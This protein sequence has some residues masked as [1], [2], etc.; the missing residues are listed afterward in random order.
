MFEARDFGKVYLIVAWVML[1]SIIAMAGEAP[2]PETA[3]IHLVKGDTA[4][5][6]VVAIGRDDLLSRWILAEMDSSGNDA[7]GRAAT[8]FARRDFASC[9]DEIESLPA[10]STAADRTHLWLREGA[11]LVE[12]NRV[13]EADSVL[14]LAI[15][16]ARRQSMPVSQCFGLLTRG[17]GRVRTR[18]VEPPR[19]DLL[20]AVV[21][22]DSL[23]LPGWGGSAAIALSVVS[24]LQMDLA[25]ALQWR[26]QALDLYL[27][28]S[29]IRGQ[30]VATHYIGTIQLMQGDLTR[31]MQ[32]F[33]DALVL[34]RNAGER[35]TEGG[36]LGEMASVNYLLGNF[37]EA[38][39]QYHE[40]IRL[41]NNPWQRGMMLINIGSIHEYRGQYAEA[42][43]VQREAL[44]LMRQV[45]DHRTE[46]AA[47]SSLG[48][49]LCEL[50]Q[51]E[52]GLEYLDEAVSV[53][54]EY[55]IPMYEAFALKSK[56]HG[57]LDSGDNA[58]AILALREAT[59]VARQIDYFEILEYSLLGQAMVARREERLTEALQYLEE[60]LTEVAAVRRRSAGSSNVTSGV[61]GQAGAIY[62]EA[63]DLLWTMHQTETG[64]GHDRRA[65]DIA[66]QAKARSFLDLLSE[67]EF[68]LKYSAVPGYR[69]AESEILTRMI[70]AE[71]TLLEAS[72]A[73]KSQRKAELAAVENELQI[74]EARLRAEDQRYA[75]VLYKK[76]L[77][78]K[79][80]QEQVL[81]PDELFLEYAL[82]DSASFV[83]AISQRGAR[84]FE[85]APRSLIEAR[86]RE[87][88]PLLKD[89]NLTGGEIAWLQPVA[90]ELARL[91]LDP[92]AAEISA[93]DRLLISPDGILHYLPFEV[94]LLSDE[95]S[96]EACD[97]PWLVKE[98]VVTVTP[99]A[100]VLASVLARPKVIEAAPWLLV[101]DPH[102]VGNQESGL[103]AKAAGAGD[104]EPLLNVAIELDVLQNLAPN[105]GTQ[106]LRAGAATVTALRE[107]GLSTSW[108]QVHFATHGL[109]N[110]DRPR[111]S[112]LVLSPDPATGDDGFL[113][114]SDVFGLQ[115]NCQQVVLSAC[116]TAL[117]ENVTGEGLVGL[118]QGFLFSGARSVIASLW[119]VS[120]SATTAFMAIYYDQL[121]RNGGDRALA[122]AVT[123]RIL[124][125]DGGNENLSHPAYWSA[126]VLSGSGH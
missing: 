80:L 68:D 2:V 71:T 58:G 82:G 7:L 51:F 47:L 125:C 48:E 73:H 63:V 111:Y 6:H 23:D 106:Q 120:G 98:K 83:W 90:R 67:A 99:S 69:Q 77:F 96:T 43:V 97:L 22:C 118:T 27:E 75:D 20:A 33:Q 74:L 70:T 41:A 64:A 21:L 37:N 35:T 66:Q 113:S 81:A 100:S 108:S 54:R 52:E 104:L 72:A 57:L 16:E 15:D 85:L 116:S 5:A 32:N 122:L 126:F 92:V 9:L 101:G 28:A 42:V 46:A 38:L 79:D 86:V 78:L 65:F 115:L 8:S 55:E 105:M 76:P 17:R 121:V 26:Q 62:R 56:G 103:F 94:L 61:V 14:T 31:A 18:K 102:L 114:V 36:V 112:G 93:S 123:K 109:L 34:A 3:W 40:A 53:A 107:I 11:C 110:E 89:I 45:G 39:V 88:L 44:A 50:K 29:D 87:L 119:D 10:S 25:D 24:R 12:L 1:G 59:K 95:T 30:A 84:M 60:A 91:L 124:I 19:Q 49:I 4:A 117:G 13:A